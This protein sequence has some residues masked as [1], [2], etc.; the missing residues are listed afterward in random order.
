MIVSAL[1]QIGT[2]EG[3]LKESAERSVSMWLN[4]CD[5]ALTLS[6]RDVRNEQLPKNE[7]QQN[8]EAVRV[9]L[10]YGRWLHFMLSD[11]E[12]GN[13]RQAAELQIRLDQLNEVWM[14]CFAEDRMSEA[15]ADKVLSAVF[16]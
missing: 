3:R 12:G 8:R 7:H 4:L 11:P 16:G 9:L 13:L 5:G 1:P 14:A 2:I 15:E 6:L 10:K